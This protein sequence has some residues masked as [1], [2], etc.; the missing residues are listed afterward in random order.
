MIQKLCGQLF[1]AFVVTI[2]VH[3]HVALASNYMYGYQ[4]YEIRNLSVTPDGHIQLACI[5]DNRDNINRHTM[6][7]FTWYTGLKAAD[8]P[9]LDKTTRQAIIIVVESNNGAIMQNYARKFPVRKR[10]HYKVDENMSPSTQGSLFIIN[11]NKDVEGLYGCTYGDLN[12]ESPVTYYVSVAP[13]GQAAAND[14][15][16]DSATTRFQF[17]TSTN[18]LFIIG[19]FILLASLQSNTN[20]YPYMDVSLF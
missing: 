1:A 11:A 13:G 4:P 7:E 15:L 9:S 3:H 16:T 20:L 5:P 17:L 19:C 2:A 14:K 10:E 12:T 8:R 6:N 18:R